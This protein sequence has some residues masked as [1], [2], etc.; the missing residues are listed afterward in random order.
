MIDAITNPVVLSVIL[1][2]LITIAG[3]YLNMRWT[4]KQLS[5]D[6]ITKMI[7]KFGDD[8]KL[9][10]DIGRC[11][12]VSKEMQESITD[13]EIEVESKRDISECRE[14]HTALKQDNADFRE[15]IGKESMEH[16]QNHK[17]T[18]SDFS[19]VK[20]YLLFLITKLG[21]KPSDARLG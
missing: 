2:G 4:R 11:D 14:F 10:Q 18:L 7:S 15:R 12:V 8:L 5:L 20:Q 1:A 16:Y 9:K 6:A 21:F 19:E 3:N 17:D 13:I